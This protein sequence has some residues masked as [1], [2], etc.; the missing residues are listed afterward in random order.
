MRNVILHGHLG[1]TF[2]SEFKF[3]VRSPAEAVRA[4]SVSL[5][6]FKRYLVDNSEPGYRVIIDGQQ[7]GPEELNYPVNSDI[8]IVPV[9]KGAGD[10]GDILLIIVGVFLLWLSWGY[11]GGIIAEAGAGAAATTLVPAFGTTM[12]LGTLAS[13]ASTAANLGMGLLLSG[14]SAALFKP[15]EQSTNAIED[16]KNT[17]FN[18]PVNITTQG[19]PV[20][21]AY[22]Q[23][24]AGSI[25]IAGSLITNGDYVPP[26]PRATY[27][28]IYYDGVLTAN[29]IMVNTAYTSLH[30]TVTR[31]IVYNSS[32]ATI[33]DLD[34]SACK[35]YNIDRP[36]SGVWPSNANLKSGIAVYPITLPAPV[37]PAKPGGAYWYIEAININA[38]TS[39][40]A[41]VPIDT[42][43]QRS[44]SGN[45]GGE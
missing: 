12:Q 30:P 39:G 36:A 1:E 8:H 21:L 4:L 20:P 43:Y 25:V 19:V 10:G 31:L 18:G 28:T 16:A 44:Y 11:A 38:T 22:G 26:K 6:G 35:V 27:T 33:D 34:I 7:F 40:I 14:I 32:A 37:D 23:V 3:D 24:L 42:E 5:K 13:I 41:S 17:N 2:G 29:N 9:V 45:E 15:P